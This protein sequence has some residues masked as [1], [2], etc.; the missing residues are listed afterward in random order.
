[1]SKQNGNGNGSL[2]YDEKRNKYRMQ[3]SYTAPNGELKRKSFS[4]DTPSEVQAKKK[5]FE[6]ELA[7]GRVTST[8]KCT[9]VE[10]LKES[11]NFDYEIG[12]IGDA[13]YTRRLF[14]I[15]VIERSDISNI[16]ITKLTEARINAFLL[17]LK[18]KYSNST[19]SKVYSAL[20]KAYRLAINKRLITY[21]L[22][23]SP[24]IKKP[25]ATKRDKKVTAFTLEE[26]NIFLEA[27]HKK[28][29][30]STYIDYNSM[31]LIELYSGLR[32]GEICALTP[33]DIDFSNGVIHVR[34]TITRNLNYE[35]VVGDT[36]KTPRG[37][38]DVP[39]TSILIDVLHKVID[40]QIDN[41]YNLIFYNKNM[42]RP[43]S[44]QQANDYFHRLCKSAG[45]QTTGGQHMLRHTFATRCIEANI[46]P[47]VLMRWLGHTDISVTINT[48]TDV[49]AKR[50]NT[51]LNMFSDYCNN[52]L[53]V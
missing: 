34:N 11:A 49:F 48:Y 50:Q 13:A 12:E 20:T 21:N 5:Q 30:Q 14:T 26:Q 18:S 17:T 2:F 6:K 44:T 24:F 38:R 31:F 43:V 28:R 25:R 23:E 8:S 4:G 51:A 29:F 39:I 53:T 42:D 10:L 45:L 3:I 41:P 9:V 16:P 47:E 46:P 22:M 27:L 7:Q 33:D 40:E 52:N 37:I 19:I 1:M 36:T 35:S 15:S 32:M